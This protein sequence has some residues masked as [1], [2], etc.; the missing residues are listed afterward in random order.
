M[1]SFHG[2]SPPWA[3]LD[4]EEGPASVAPHRDVEQAV[5]EITRFYANYQSSRYVDG[6][7]VMRVL[8]LPP[9][10]LEKLAVSFG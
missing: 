2:R 4:L 10:E 6:H 3:W 1:A 5:D 9:N 7:L 8:R